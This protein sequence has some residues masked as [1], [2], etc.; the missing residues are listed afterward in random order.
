MKNITFLMLLTLCSFVVNPAV[1]Q[2]KTN[3]E[4]IEQLEK[5][6]EQII[7]EEKEA[8]KLEVEAINRRA[9]AKEIDWEEAEKMKGEAARKHAMNIQNRVAIIDNQIALLTREEGAEEFEW[10]DEE[11]EDDDDHWY[12][13]SKYSRTSTH[14]VLAVGFNNALTED[15]SINDSDFKVG[16]SRFFELGIAWR[17]RVFEQ[18]NFMRLRYG[19]SFQFNG[20]KPT[21]NRFFVEDGDLTMLEEYPLDLDK[22]KFRMDNLVFPVHFEFGP[23][24]KVETPR[25]VWFSTH[26]KLKIGLG[27]YAGVNLG[28]RQKLKYEEDGEKVKEKLKGDYNTNDFIYGLSGYLGWGDASIYVKYD[29]NPIF[30]DPNPEM[31]NISIGL[32]FDAN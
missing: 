32:R 7:A 17:T 13:K 22:S 31:R 27:G 21:D 1:A 29:L 3:S 11:E 14:L 4:K 18:S 5:Q 6:K 15:Q 10:E 26:N 24:K 20:L 8:L 19:F 23:S 12:N 2:E 30:K 16:G 9:Q 28:E 25:S